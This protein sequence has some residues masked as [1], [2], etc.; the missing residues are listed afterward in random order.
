M[1]FICAKKF[2]IPKIIILDFGEMKTKEIFLLESKLNFTHF[3]STKNYYCKFQRDENQKNILK[4]SKPKF[5]HFT[6]TKN[7]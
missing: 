1:L 2:Q 5:T 3:I 7:I 4:G 6:Q